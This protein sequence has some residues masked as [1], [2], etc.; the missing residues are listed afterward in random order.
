MVWFELIVCCIIIVFAGT[1]LAR[2]GDALAERTGLGRM[3]IGL[4]LIA[5]VTS[6]P[7]MVT[8]ISSAVI[9]KQPDLALGNF[10]GSC[11]FNLSILAII[12]VIYRRAPVLSVSS[13]RNILP[14]VAG[15]SLISI[16]TLAILIGGPAVS[17]ALGRVG[18]VSFVLFGLYLMSI[19]QMYLFDIKHPAEV[20][21]K[22]YLYSDLPARKMYAGFSLSALAI[23]GAGIWL[24]LIGEEIAVTYNLNA[25]FVGSLFL[26]IGTSL[27]ELVV[28]ITAVRI[29][30]IDLAVGDILGANMLN[31]TN[32]F[33]TDVF[34][35][36]G[37]LLAAVSTRNLV[38]ALAVIL[39]TLVVIIGLKFKH[40]RK[41]F[42]VVSWY[43]IALILM[44]VTASSI[45][46]YS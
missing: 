5:L 40:Q 41:I 45:L 38:T 10:W 9:V 22:P 25:S 31:T 18:I 11:I 32:I 33:I 13:S 12:D 27:P 46:F 1:R 37:P 7:E 28:A 43:S 36:G 2:Y 26:A 16:A 4:V 3:W 17:L 20:E 42:N 21:E 15:I 23:I 34:Y 6:M 30:A 24:S 29:G 35:A 44:Y 8:G 39:M 14:A 19:R